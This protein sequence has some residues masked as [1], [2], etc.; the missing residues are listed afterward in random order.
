[1]S[2]SWQSE[3]AHDS[4]P[5]NMRQKGAYIL[6]HKISKQHKNIRETGSHTTEYIEAG[7]PLG[8]AGMG[9]RELCSLP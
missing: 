6:Q 3:L 1:M 2:A 5:S 4:L 9:K 8:G 7:A